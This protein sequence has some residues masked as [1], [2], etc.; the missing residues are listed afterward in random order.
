MCIGGGGLEVFVKKNPDF[1]SL[2]EEGKSDIVFTYDKKVLANTFAFFFF[3]L[4]ELSE[5]AV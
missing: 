5:S 4:S 3:F 1:N 2:E